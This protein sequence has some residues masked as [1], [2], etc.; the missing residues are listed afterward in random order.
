[1]PV[2]LL[3]LHAYRSWRPDHPRG[4]VRQGEGILPPDAE[5]AAQYDRNA[6][7]RQVTFD[8]EL[9]QILVEGTCDICDRRDWRLHYVATEPTHIHALVSWLDDTLDW[10]FAHDTLKR[11]LGMMLAQHTRTKGRKWFVRKGSRKRV[12]DCGHFEYLMNEYLPKHRGRRWSERV[13][14]CTRSQ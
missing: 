9:Q 12:R 3:T 6:T 11:L 2:Y 5:M 4:Y 13:A 14:A 8:K 7:H 10:K 1:M